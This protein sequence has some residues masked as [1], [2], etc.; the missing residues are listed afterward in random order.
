MYC[1]ILG[2]F[3]GSLSPLDAF[4]ASALALVSMVLQLAWGDS[5]LPLELNARELVM[6]S[7]GLIWAGERWWR[8]WG[9]TR[10]I[11]IVQYSALTIF[12]I[13]HCRSLV[14]AHTPF[15]CLDGR[16]SSHLHALHLVLGISTR[17]CD[18]PIDVCVCA[19]MRNASISF[20]LSLTPWLNLDGCV[21]PVLNSWLVGRFIWHPRS[22]FFIVYLTWTL[23][24]G[25]RCPRLG[26]LCLV[27]FPA[28][29]PPCALTGRHVRW[30]CG[31]I[32]MTLVVAHCILRVSLWSS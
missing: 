19:S 28:P 29:L 14:C 18:T 31:C 2:R 12:F 11:V 9:C 5:P 20:G 3:L 13:S 7:G 17:P 30:F 8:L 27:A 26:H 4:K 16:F 22:T 1:A 6:L 23:L 24:N 21:L 25:S 15:L 32:W 10:C